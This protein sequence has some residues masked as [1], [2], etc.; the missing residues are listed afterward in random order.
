MSQSIDERL[1]RLEALMEG[2]N[3]RVTEMSRALNG[4]DDRMRHIESS[5]VEHR[6]VTEKQIQMIEQR[7]EEIITMLREQNQKIAHLEMWR[8]SITGIAA[9]VSAIVSMAVAFASSIMKKVGLG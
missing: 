3:S 2:V 6:A 7:L 5:A 9:A 4:R 1:A 8:A